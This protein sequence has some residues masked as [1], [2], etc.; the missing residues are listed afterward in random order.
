M[1]FLP[2]QYVNITVPGTDQNRSYSFSNSPHDDRL[3]FLVKLTPGG[4]MSDY[5]AHAPP[6]ATPIAF[7]GP[8]GRFFLRETDAP[9]LLLAGGTGLAPSCRCC[10]PCGPP[11]SQRKAHLIY[12]VSTDED[13]VELDQIEEIASTPGFTWDHCVADPQSTAEQQ[14]LRDRPHRGRRTSTTATSRSTSADRP[15]WSR[16]Y[17]PT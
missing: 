15:R 6:S 13:L 7:T 11:S 3:T 17:A 14:G 10:A 16:R 9:V 1:A 5:L 4:A 8:N 2:G 12:G